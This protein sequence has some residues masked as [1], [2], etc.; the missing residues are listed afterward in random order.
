VNKYQRMRQ[1]FLESLDEPRHT[2]EY[3]GVNGQATI[4]GVPTGT[5]GRVGESKVRRR[6][7][8]VVMEPVPVMMRDAVTIDTAIRLLGISRPTL[9]RAITFGAIPSL[10][11]GP[12]TSPYL[13]RIR[14]V[15]TF[16]VTMWSDRKARRQLAEDDMY[17][18]F[19]E[20]LVEKV[21]EAWPA[22]SVVRPG[23]WRP[24]YVKL[25]RGG[26]PRGIP[27]VRD[28]ERPGYS[29]NGKRL[30][31]PPAVNQKAPFLVADSEGTEWIEEKG[32]APESNHPKVPSPV[33]PPVPEP[34]K[35]E[36]DPTTLPKWH[37][38]WRRPSG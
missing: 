21:A 8:G 28:P 11:T 27:T 9:Q 1:A 12:G 14:D 38:R 35:P 10:K 23:N 4:Q 3:G 20:W 17:R 36:V 30:G 32:G 18:G 22:H 19:P 5:E 26:R 13:V 37:P 15:V 34:P 6:N 31:R 2:L 16:M 29:A 25:K 24:S 7:L 33:P